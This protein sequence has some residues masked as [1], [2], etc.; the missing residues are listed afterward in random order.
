MGWALDQDGRETT[1]PARA[2]ESLALLPFGGYKAFGL[3][4]V[5]EILTSVL[6]GGPLRAGESAGFAPYDGAMNTSFSLQAI[7]I[8]AFMP[9]AEFERRTEEF[10]EA[11]KSVEPTARDAPVLFPGERSLAELER[12]QKDGIPVIAGIMDKLRAWARE[13]GVQPLPGAAVKNS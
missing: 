9:V 1:D 4:M 13:V 10:I 7:D 11:V 8:S 6:S 2:L 5:H 12:R 3:G